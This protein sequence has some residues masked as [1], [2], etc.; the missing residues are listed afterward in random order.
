[1]DWVIKVGGILVILAV[2][3]IL[4]FIAS[5]IIPLVKK[6]RI[7]DYQVISTGGESA[8]ALGV[9]EWSEL[10]VLVGEDGSLTF[11]RIG[12]GEMQQE[13][14][15]PSLPE[16]FKPTTIRYLPFLQSILLGSDDGQVA[17][18]ALN[19]RSEFAD[20][21]RT[22]HADPER[23]GLHRVADAGRVVDV[24]YGKEGNET[25]K[26][27]FTVA[28]LVDHEGTV[29][30]KVMTL[31]SKKDLLGRTSI[32]P[33]GQQDLT[34]EITGTPVRVDVS[35][36]NFKLLVATAEGTVFF[37]SREGDS[38]KFVQQ[39]QPFAPGDAI[40]EL[41]FLNGSKSI[42][43]FAESGIN[44]AYSLYR[45]REGQPSRFGRIKTF[46]KLAQA[47]TR[48]AASTRNKGF[49][50]AGQNELSVR[51]LTT[52]KIRWAAQIDAPIRE[53]ALSGKF[54]RVLVLDAKQRLHMWTY[55]DPHPEASWKT[56]WGKIWYEG[57]PKA[58]YVW[59]S[60]GGSDT[61]EP[62]LS[63][64][65]L[66]VGTLKATLWAMLFAVP[67]ALLA[68]IYTSRFLHQRWRR[69]VKPTMEI[70]AS[71]P[72]VILG[73]IAGLVLA[74]MVENRVPGI[75]LFL[76]LLPIAAVVF[77]WLFSTLNTK[78]QI[79]LV[80]EGRE[81]FL[82]LPVVVLLWFVADGLGPSLEEALFWVEVDGQR[83]ADFKTWLWQTTHLTYDQRN[84]AIVGFAMG[85]AVIPIIFTLSE[86][87]LANVP[88][89]LSSASL[90]LGASRWQTAVRVVIP[91]ASPGI[92]SALMIGLG[93]AVGET[94]IVLMA[95]GNTPLTNWNPFQGM[96][97]LSANLAVELPE[98]PQG[99]TLYRA[100]FM[101]ALI[102]FLMTFVINTIAELL[103]QH[104]R[105]KYKTV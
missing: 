4:V 19:Y 73:F 7:S 90:A 41:G 53:V 74:P 89:T 2:L 62:K 23:T 33:A 76:V 21:V 30:V 63:M 94:M 22:I 77:G 101:G 86:D 49:I 80:P 26:I 65:P 88:P 3:G 39:F 13:T 9:D 24:S 16:G 28:A 17:T 42:V 103:R 50:A 29:Q 102:L 20:G 91:T 70:M 92:F 48:L 105:N 47:A 93:R 51:H 36:D 96:R 44:E 55:Y 45:T 98:A 10:P 67:I 32:K 82:L 46:P 1:M 57:K 54:D 8:V 95:A 40:S 56:F 72:S 25:G 64:I 14:C 58:E 31:R 87:A 97:T 78:Y 69:V 18:V 71:L 104:L 43:L 12:E 61:I 60:G 59:Q 75:L 83:V 27:G 100:L 99:G 5:E 81:F 35:Q 37:F 68:A 52:A 6:A 66:V 15:E 84:A 79:T 38:F 34:A 11:L 85:F